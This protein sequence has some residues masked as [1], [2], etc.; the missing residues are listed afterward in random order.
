MRQ[1]G[2]ELALFLAIFTLAVYLRTVNLTEI[3]PFVHDDEAAYGLDSLALRDGQV[4]N[5][6]D[7][8]WQEQPRLTGVPGAIV[9]TFWHNP[10][11]AQRLSTV[12]TGLLTLPFLYLLARMYRRH[13][14]GIA[15]RFP[16]GCGRGRH[17]FQPPG[18]EHDSGVAVDGYP[19]V[20]SAARRAAAQRSPAP[21][22]AA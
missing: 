10:L 11:A 13:S 22:S 14:G 8:A 16:V 12:L 15:D 20:L 18:H 3:P 1:R 21:S 4:Q 19:A 9:A 6:F 2:I 17:P 7:N 5:L